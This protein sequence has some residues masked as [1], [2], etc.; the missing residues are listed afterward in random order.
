MKVEEM[1]KQIQ[2]ND[3]KVG[4]VGRSVRRGQEEYMK[5]EQ[6]A[7]LAG[8]GEEDEFIKCFDDITGKEL[9]WQ[10]VKQAREQ[11]LM[12][13]RELGVYTKVDEHAAV[14]KYNVTP[15]DTQWVD[16]D[17]AF[18]VETMQIRSRV[19]ARE[20]KKW[21]HG[22]RG[23]ASNWER[24]WQGHIENWGYELGSRKSVSQQEKENLGVDTR[25]R[26]C[27]DRN[28]GESVGAQEAAGERVPIKASIIGAG[29]AKST[30]ALNRRIRWGETGI[31]YQHE[32]RH[33]YVLVGNLRLENG[34]TVQTSI[35]DDVKDEN[36]VW[37]D[38]EQISKYRSHVAR[39]LFL[40][41]DR[42]DTTFVVTELCQRMSDL[43]DP[44]QHSFVKMKRLVRYLKGERQWIQVFEFGNMS[45][46]V[47]VFQTHTGPETHETRKSSSVGVAIVGRH[48]LK[49]YTSKQKI[50]VRKQ[51]CMQQ[52]WDYQKRNASRARCATWVL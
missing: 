12:Y 30:K 7:M 29:S 22:T 3:A 39:C 46:E 9:P 44:T 10:A 8:A 6:D 37:F 24:D 35:V 52:H 15:I 13:L 28:E 32:P 1:L 34:N 43:S 50:I 23:A 20:F 51:S 4:K 31:L 27:G 49:A 38:P 47:K 5:P 36:P 11:E 21:G 42:A 16:T 14:A 2:M 26:L 48:L 33:V 45:S 19:M 40:S 25:S 18:E 41:Q 17:K